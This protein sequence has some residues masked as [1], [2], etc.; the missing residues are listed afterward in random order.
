MFKLK[1]G[2]SVQFVSR[3]IKPGEHGVCYRPC[4]I[5]VNIP[6]EFLEPVQP[7]ME[8]PDFMNIDKYNVS[9]VNKKK[10]KKKKKK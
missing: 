6:I 2:Y 1:K 4:D 10:K 9:P 3:P 8:I 7:P 5:E